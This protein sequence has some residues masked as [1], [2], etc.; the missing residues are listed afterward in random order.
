MTMHHF[1]HQLLWM[2]ASA[3]IGFFVCLFWVKR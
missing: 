3:A 2:A 1:E